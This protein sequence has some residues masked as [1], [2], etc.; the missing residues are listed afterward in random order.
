MT[1]EGARSWLVALGLTAVL[2][3][4]KLSGLPIPWPVVVL[5]IG[6]M[7]VLAVVGLVILG[8]LLAALKRWD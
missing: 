2:V 1:R 4:L 5:P 3:L 8:L 7:I 6:A